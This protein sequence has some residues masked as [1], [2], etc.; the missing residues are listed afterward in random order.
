VNVRGVARNEML[1][2]QYTAFAP[3]LERRKAVV[4]AG[5]GLSWARPGMEFSLALV[6]ESREFEGQRAPHRFGS[7]TLHAAF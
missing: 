4:R 7:L 2:R 6:Q 3:E 1:R 5:G